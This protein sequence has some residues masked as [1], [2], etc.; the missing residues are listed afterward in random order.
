MHNENAIN[1]KNAID[2][3]PIPTALVDSE[4]NTIYLNNKFTEKYGYT[5]SD[6]RPIQKW[7]KVAYPEKYWRNQTLDSWCASLERLSSGGDA[8]PSVERTIKCKNGSIKEVELNF[9]K[10]DN[11]QILITFSDMSKY[12]IAEKALYDS[13]VMFRELFR[14][15]PIAYQSLDEKGNFIDINPA[16]TELLGYSYEDVKGKWFGDLLKADYVSYF[17]S[18]Y[19]NFLKNGCPHPYQFHVFSKSG[20]LILIELMGERGYDANGKF[21]QLH[22]L[23]QNITEREIA[24]FELKKQK[25]TA[26][27]YLDI[28]DVMIIASDNNI[29]VTLINKKGCQV[30]GYSEDELIGINGFELCVPEKYRH[31]YGAYFMKIVTGE[32]GE[33]NDVEL[34]VLTKK[35]DVRLIRWQVSPIWEDGR[36][37][38]VLTSGNDVTE[39]KIAET[40]LILDESRLE[41]LVELNHMTDSSVYDVIHF[42][43]EKAVELTCSQ[44]GYIGFVN[45]DE[46]AISMHSWSENAIN[47]CDITV[48]ST[49]F[50]VEDIGLWGDSVRNKKAVISNDISHDCFTE[51]NYPDGHISINSH[52]GVPILHDGKVVS[53]VGVGNK[54]EDYN[55]SDIRQITLL[56]EGLWK[57]IKKR[58]DESKLK[59]YAEE[60]ARKN[61]E[62]SSLDILKDEFLS[63]ITHELK[64]P[65]ISIKG[66]SDLLSEEHIGPLNDDQKL[67]VKS[68]VKGS[69]RLQRLVDSI[70]Y[71]QNIHSGNVEYNSDVIFI[72]DFVEKV[73]YD[74]SLIIGTN[75]NAIQT[76]I[77]DS[78]PLLSGNTDY[79]EQVFFHI[80]DNAQKFSSDSDEIKITV[81]HEG[82][83][84]HAVIEDHG[85]GISEEQLPHIFK[86]F[87]Q[88]DG[89][90]ERK[91]GGNGIGLHLCKSIVEAH[92]GSMWAESELG[93][94]TKIHV[95]LPFS[96]KC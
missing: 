3:S 5:L 57:I 8:I 22:C 67:S 45:E 81:L 95:K 15:S 17:R 18:S 62:L 87:Y 46:S 90:R 33:I 4:W 74:I 70:L 7:R 55:N 23:I 30:L 49:E 64:T 96:G 44:V 80:I 19:E 10:M 92:G 79:L 65:L 38:G 61:N 75:I 77:P 82:E 31:I 43:L 47:E 86:R 83:N 76:D 51:D 29:N 50:L 85:I 94:G 39:R 24:N 9:S 88:A 48:H 1:F 58:Q 40:A 93:V 72:K 21:S 26:Q 53:I 20:N 60:L 37:V 73:L 84:M 91:Y 66:Y 56:M 16:W 28:V 68:I 63:N 13:K 11:G 32:I 34:P 42:A 6:V 89:S 52:L 71:L 14:N 25:E 35:G 2:I 59:K 78:L 12:K 27:H 54:E 41:A 36:I 69:E